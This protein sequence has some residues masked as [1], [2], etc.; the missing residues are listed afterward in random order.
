MD[1][2][3]FNI[4]L[5]EDDEEDYIIVKALL[6]EVRSMKFDIDWAPT[7]E[8]GLAKLCD[9]TSYDACLLDYRLGVHDGLE[10]LHESARM[11][12]NIPIIVLTGQGD[13]D[14]DLEAMRAGAADYLVKGLITKELLERTI[15]YSIER[16]RTET[17][18]RNARDELEIRVQERTADLEAANTALKE[19]EERYRILVESALDI[20]YTVSVQGK[21]ESVNPAFETVTGWSESDWVGKD[22]WAL[23]HPDDREGTLHRFRRVLRG[24]TSPSELRIVSRSGEIKLLEC[25]SVPLMRRGKVTGIV[26]TARDVTERRRMEEA[27]RR[28]ND[29]LEVRVRERTA[30]LAK[31]N[32]ALRVDEMR[33]QALWNLSQMNGASTK[34][35][36]DFVL[37]EQV[38]ITGSKFGALGF[39]NETE[40]VMTAYGWSK[41]VLDVCGGG[42][43][44][45]QWPV[46]ENCIWAEAMKSRSHLILNDRNKIKLSLEGYPDPK[47]IE[48]LMTVPVF[49]GERIVALAVVG[50][51]DT[52]YD[53]SDA[54]QI[55][56]L[57]DGMWSLIRRERAEKAL[58]EAES[59]AA[60]GR[61]LSGVAHD[62]KTPLIAIGGFTRIVQNHL[63]SEN[64]DWKKLD[65]V[66]KETGRLEKMVKD[67]LD[68]S[69]PLEL[70]RSREDLV[71]VV[72][73]TFT[74]LEP[75]ANE[76]GVRLESDLRRTAPVLID[77]M[78]MKQALMNL[79]LNAIQ[80]SPEGRRVTTRI[81]TLGRSLVLEVIDCGCGIPGDKRR[82]IF[83]P[84]FTTKKEGTGLGLPIVKKIVEA[85]SGCIEVVDNPDVGVTFRVS[86]PIAFHEEEAL[87]G[88][89]Q[90]CVNF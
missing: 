56:L 47:P 31:A 30:E 54:R 44:R 35:I 12:C 6:S 89:E 8:E 34:E 24:E 7:Y 88:E 75:V 16:K 48:R 18:L 10:L 65:I 27:L 38:R 11:S 84:F 13:H 63:E 85:H 87:T 58:R 40:T 55:S 53:D 83:S 66:L 36:A 80:A 28:A 4:L 69:R 37:G 5:I 71:D 1:Q 76:R 60:M 23:L 78:R 2:L 33:L 3:H 9:P 19:S 32:E 86:I 49:D 43:K 70:N 17:A 26:G 25:M 52:D 73:E 41:D 64:A 42:G 74:L 21:I 50:D 51:K 20:I 79:L 82:E 81:D 22:Y 15:R 90:Y 14:I 61:A 46:A 72:L 62:I 68:F 57:L 39:M 77:P 67:M 59:L 45:A 29:V